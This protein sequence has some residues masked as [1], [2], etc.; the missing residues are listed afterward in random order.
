M[1][2]ADNDAPQDRDGRDRQQDRD[3]AERDAGQPI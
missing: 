2:G 3:D 1:G